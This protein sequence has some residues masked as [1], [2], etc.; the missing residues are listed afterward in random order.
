MSPQKNIRLS[1]PSKGR[2]ETGALEFLSESGLQVFKPNP[3]QY[4]AE[5]PACLIWGS[6]FN[7]PVTSSSVCGRGALIL[8]LRE[9]ICSKK[10]A[11]PMAISSFCTIRS[12]LE[13]AL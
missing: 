6:S 1:L 10:N 7:A 13:A 4:L 8:A 11:A 12:A 2:L 3:R 9:S 5:L